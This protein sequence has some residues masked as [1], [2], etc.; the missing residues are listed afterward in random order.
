MTIFIMGSDVNK[1]RYDA[2]G[3]RR[4]AAANRRAVLE[5]AERLFLDRGYAS[6]SIPD[7]AA[8][9]GVAPQTVYAAFGNKRGLLQR[10]MDVRIAGDEEAVPLLDRDWY[11]RLLA[12]PDAHRLLRGH[13]HSVRTILERSIALTLLLRQAAGADPEVDRDYRS[14]VRERRFETQ[15][16]VAD[17]LAARG[18]L[19]EGLTAGTAAD[20]LWTLS[21]PETYESLVLDRR[22]TPDAFEEW[23]ACALA[24][25][26]LRVPR[27]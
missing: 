19:R 15:R 13:A 25:T 1:R 18:A 26:L 7:I 24:A 22:W 16:A 8:D 6:T 27:S 11:T 10:L 12:E 2:S 17:E 14:L 4:Q 5:T 20:I 3:R 9:A 23:L 21:S